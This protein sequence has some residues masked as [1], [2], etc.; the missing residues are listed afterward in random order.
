MFSG[1][2]VNS[3]RYYLDTF[4]QQSAASVAQ[5]ALVLDAGAGNCPYRKHFSNARYES[6]DFGQVDKAYGDITYRC[7]LSTIPV[8]DNRYDMVCLIQVLEHLPEPGK[9]LAE[10]FRVLK[11]GKALWLS[12]PLY[13]EEHETPY[14]FY[15]YTQFG[16][17]YQLEQVGFK[18]ERIEWL[19]GYL[20]TLSYQCLM[21]GRALPLDPASYGDGTQIAFTRRRAF[22]RTASLFSRWRG[23]R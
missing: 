1:M 6:A 2:I 20:G 19:E 13:Y 17:R 3:S 22:V 18:V 15:R 9:V 8:E 21:A 5:N 10:M 14:D 11:P 12:A 7:D 4:A 16:F 23:N